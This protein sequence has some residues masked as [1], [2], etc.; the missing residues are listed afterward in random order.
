MPLGF[1]FFG[2]FFWPGRGC[3]AGNTFAGHTF[4]VSIGCCVGFSGPGLAILLA[5]LVHPLR[6]GPR[7]EQ[8]KVLRMLLDKPMIL[9]HHS[10]AWNFFDEASAENL[11]RNDLDEFETLGL[12]LLSFP[13]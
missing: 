1:Y 3:G 12:R 2:L 10:P 8:S 5:I 7:A 6:V 4:T 9:R 11:H 13:R